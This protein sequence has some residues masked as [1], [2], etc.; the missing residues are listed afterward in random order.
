MQLRVKLLSSTALAA[1]AA[2]AA[3]SVSAQDI[4][5]L[6]KR[7]QALEKSGGG[8]YVARSKKTMNLVVSGHVNQMMQYRDNGQSSAVIF[9]GNGE[10]ETRFRFVGTGNISDDLS[11]RTTIELGENSSSDQLIDSN[12]LTNDQDTFRVR[13]MTL[14][15]SSKSMGTFSLGDGS[16]ATDGYHGRAD[17][18]GTTL[19]QTAG[20]AMIGA[21]PFKNSATGAN[22]GVTGSIFSNL[23]AGRTDRIRYDSPV[24]GGFQFVTSL[25]NEDN[26]NYGLNYGGDF[27]GVKVKAAIAY[28]R[29]KDGNGTN[30]PATPDLDSDTIN[31]SIG[32]LLPM[33]LNFMVGAADRDADTTDQDRLYVKVGYMFNATELGQTRLAIDWSQN[34]TDNATNDEGERWSLGVVQ[35]V[36]PLGAEVYAAYHNFAAERTGVSIDDID[37]VT[38]G[39][40]ISF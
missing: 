20:N 39:M 11:V 4:G 36:E 32:V 34:E 37:I 29:L 40:R 27:G 28:D 16:L 21:E 14:A 31:G 30:T 1:V 35:V 6:E 3:S 9:S 22:S 13:Q 19:V 15:L 12:D 23:D 10:S 24:F 38:A 26:Q 17:M 33:G 18:S 25:A 7:V 8:Q 5:A 2:L